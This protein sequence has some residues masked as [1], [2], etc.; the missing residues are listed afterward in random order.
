[1]IITTATD[2]DLNFILKCWCNSSYDYAKPGACG[3]VYKTEL[4]KYIKRLYANPDIAFVVAKSD[5]T[6][7]GFMVAQ[8]L[9]QD[10]V[11]V[12]YAYTKRIYRKL[13]IQRKLYVEQYGNATM[14]IGE[15]NDTVK[16]IAKTHDIQFN[17]WILLK[18]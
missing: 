18:E 9:T 7:H 10:L 5:N 6:I 16:R 2:A 1:M 14:L 8:Q 13:G 4:H 12:H 11:F 3:R 17:P 15:T